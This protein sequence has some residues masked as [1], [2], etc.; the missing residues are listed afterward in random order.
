MERDAR[1]A[2]QADGEAPREADAQERRGEARGDHEL[3]EPV[4]LA[5]EAGVV[6]GV[7][8]EDE[9]LLREDGRD[10]EQGERVAAARAG[11][12]GAR[13]GAD[14][15]GARRAARWPASGGA[16]QEAASRRASGAGE[17]EAERREESGSRFKSLIFGG[18]ASRRK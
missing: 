18:Q 12:V 6:G 14:R 17:K 3:Q 13:A 7:E 11:A 15:A 9:Q 2:D 10:E 5:L 4:E 16:R 1:R 8:V